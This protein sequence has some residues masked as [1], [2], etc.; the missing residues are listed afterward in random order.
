VVQGKYYY[1][2]AEPSER[3]T[4]VKHF[5]RTYL[6]KEIELGDGTEEEPS[7]EPEPEA[8]TNDKKEE[9]PSGF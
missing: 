1:A 8:P 9:K 7:A 4:F 5:Y 2:M 6:G 3:V